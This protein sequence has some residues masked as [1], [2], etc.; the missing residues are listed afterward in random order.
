MQKLYYLP[1]TLMLVT[2]VMS[3]RAE[4]PEDTIGAGAFGRPLHSVEFLSDQPFDRAHLEGVLPVKPGSLLTRTAVKASIQALYDTGRFSTITVEA[5]AGGQGIDL[6]FHVTLNFYFNNFSVE[7]APKLG[8]RSLWELLKLPVGE[9]FTLQRLEETRKGVE[10]LMWDRGFSLAQAEVRTSSNAQTRQ[11]DT[12]FVIRPGSRTRVAALD[13]QGV[14]AASSVEIRERIGYG[15]GSLLDRQRLRRRLDALK[16]HLVRRGYLAAV[17]EAREEFRPDD[18]TVRLILTVANLGRVRVVVEGYNIEKE[19]IR[20]LL[21]VLTGEGLQPEL[22]DEGARNIKEFVEERGYPEAEVKYQEDRDKDGVRVLRY[23]VQP[24]R[25]VTIAWV[26]FRGNKAISEHDLLQA[27]QTQPSRFLQKSVYS[28]TRLEADV[29]SLK[30][31]YQSRGYLEATFIPLLEPV[32]GAQK[33]G[34]SFECE[35]GPLSRIKSVE[36]AGNAGLPEK[37]LASSMTLKPGEPYSPYIA[38]RDRQALV[39]AYNDAGFAQARVNYRVG[40]PDSERQVPVVFDIQEGMRSYVGD[41]VI[42]GNERTRRSVIENRLRFKPDEPLSLGK[43]LQT[44]QALHNLG[45]F[46]LVRVAPQNP[47]SIAPFQNVVV[48]VQETKQLTLRYGFGY[49]EREHLRG[50]VE[51]SDFNIFGTGQRADLRLRG[52]RIEQ[53]AALTFQQPQIRFLP[54]NSYFTVSLR[55]KR[56]VSFDVTRGNLSYQYSHPLGGHTWALFRYSYDNVRV[57]T[58]DLPAADRQNQPRNLSTFSFIY[59]NDTRDNYLDPEKGF[60]TSTD[61]G[62]TTKLIGERSYFVLYTQNG[63]Y[64]KLPGSLLF[65]AGLKIGAARSL[66]SLPDLPISE[67]FFAGGGSSL[68]GFETDRAGPL[69]PKTDKPQGGNALIVGNAEIRIPVWRAVHLAGFYD[70]G[71]VFS[72]ISDIRPADFSHTVGIGFRIKTPFGPLRAD[73]GINLNLPSAKRDQGLNP[74]NLFITIGPPF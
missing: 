46:D 58:S 64:R 12:V 37:S 65:A 57:S 62:L 21:P 52:S 34:I 20:R 74:R 17:P 24:G 40:E 72:R 73:Y 28:V 11:V 30:T 68:R 1:L 23:R 27:V 59:I 29:D 26:R 19:R 38:D 39:A 32:K 61:F 70:S 41:V 53:G 44:Q 22:L 42:L 55:K 33:L 14:P 36:L 16:Q 71:N 63:Y 7:G 3:A 69:F 8:R 43:M 50:T 13:L 6:T 66:D 4:T 45:I 15:E 35:E 5:V 47:D 60:F 67:R 51:L 48:R 10:A 25:R 56:E 18:N 31:L 9:R 54:V 49:Q 2:G